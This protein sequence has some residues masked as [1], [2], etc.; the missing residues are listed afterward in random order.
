MLDIV[1]QVNDVLINI[2]FS[3]VSQ[4]LF[5]KSSILLGATYVTDVV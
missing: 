4:H 2:S 3:F 5:V 1:F